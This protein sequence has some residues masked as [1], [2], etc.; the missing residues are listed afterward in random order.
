[1]ILDLK[2]LITLYIQRLV[3]QVQEK[4]EKE[5]NSNVNSEFARS[6]T[7]IDSI[8]ENTDFII[9][10]DIQNI[11]NICLDGSFFPY[12]TWWWFT[13]PMRFCG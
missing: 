2:Q 9:L 4:E 6:V 8:T 12:I 10:E 1:M 7:T 13:Y 3:V 5:L 11:W